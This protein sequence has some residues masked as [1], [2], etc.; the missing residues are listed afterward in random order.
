MTPF[1]YLAL[2]GWIPLVVVMFAILPSRRAATIAVIGAWLI[3]PPYTIQIANLPDF[4]KNM[5][6]TVGMLLS[7]LIFAP[8]RILNFRPRWFDLP[9]LLWCLCG[10]AS[11]LQNGLGIYDGLSD[12][13]GQVLSLGVALPARADVLRHP[14]GPALFRRR[15]GHRR[16][17]LRAPLPLGKP[18]EPAA[19]AENLRRR[20]LGG[21]T[22]GRLSPASLLLVRARMRDVDDGRVA[23]GLV[24]VATA[25]PS[26]GSGTSRS[27][28][29]SCRSCW[30]RPSSAARPGH[31]PCSSAA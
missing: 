5:A 16:A 19:P 28:R 7:T 13:L 3:L 14:G 27:A 26:R 24:A 2:L 22:A 11:S 20:A 29:C 23:R 6:A 18:D 30:G 17:L 9:M 15:H 12:A 21:N 10:I 4:S 31:W 25:V 1:A 8:D